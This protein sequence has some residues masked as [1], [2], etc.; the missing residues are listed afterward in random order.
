MTVGRPLLS[1]AGEREREKEKEMGRLFVCVIFWAAAICRLRRGKK[2]GSL[3]S[4]GSWPILL[5]LW[6][7]SLT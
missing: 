5:T 1:S 7:Q 2:R 6:P 3:R 4:N